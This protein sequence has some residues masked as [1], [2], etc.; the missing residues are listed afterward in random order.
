[1]GTEIIKP[2]A[3]DF[4]IVANPL[5]LGNISKVFSSANMKKTGMYVSGFEFS[6]D[7]RVTSI[8]DILDIHKH[9]MKKNDMQ[10]KMFGFITKMFVVA[11]AFFNFNEI[12]FNPLNVNSLEFVPMDNHVC[13]TRAKIINVNN[14]ESVF[15][16]FSIKVNK[17]SGS[18][19]NTNEPCA[20]LCVPDIVKNV[21]VKVFNLISCSF[22]TRH[23]K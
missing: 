6:V 15:Y 21:N 19:N 20:K 14:N 23:I 1:M 16:P 2:K 8:D 18:C 12:G 17:C 5:C 10:S 4:E 9:L 22:P 3:K 11:M 7:Y 13:R